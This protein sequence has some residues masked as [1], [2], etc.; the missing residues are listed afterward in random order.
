MRLKGSIVDNKL[1]TTT[2]AVRPEVEHTNNLAERKPQP[3]VV[4]RKI[5][6]GNRSDRGAKAH[7]N[8][9]SLIVTSQQKGKDWLE[10]GN[11]VMKHFRDNLKEPVIS[12]P[13]LQS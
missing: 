1:I 12:T 9:M 5:S 2:F 10:Y 13:Q 7:E 3:N 8:L 4:I 6:S 11:A